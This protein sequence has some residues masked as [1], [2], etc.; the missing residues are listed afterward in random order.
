MGSPAGFVSFSQVDVARAF[1]P[2]TLL[3]HG[4][5]SQ[6]RVWAQS[7]KPRTQAAFPLLTKARSLGWEEL[8]VIRYGGRANRK[9]KT[10]QFSISKMCP[11]LGVGHCDQ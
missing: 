3:R 10:P 1:P 9:R 8:G 11:L 6:G 4:R 2:T 5:G 7:A